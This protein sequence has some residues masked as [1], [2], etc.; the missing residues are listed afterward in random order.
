MTDTRTIGQVSKHTGM[1]V[2][3]IRY[4]ESEG[5]VVPV[6]RS[7]GGYRLFTA[8]DVRRLLL[9]KQARFLG[10]T[11]D[12]VKAVVI[13]ASSLDCSAFAGEL[14]ARITERRA[15]VAARIAELRELEST[16]ETLE[17]HIDNCVCRPGMAAA[18]CAITLFDT[19]KGELRDDCSCL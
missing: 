1:S 3:T 14:S 2:S 12:E 17:A 8:A 11:L 18:D 6:A 16:L 4:Y 13:G 7:E 10:L 5:I 19:E 15:A 9:A